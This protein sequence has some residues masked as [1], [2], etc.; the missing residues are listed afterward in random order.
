MPSTQAPGT[1][2][3]KLG[4]FD[5]T[6]QTGYGWNDQ[7]ATLQVTAPS[8]PLTFTESGTASPASVAPGGTVDYGEP[9]G[10]A[11]TIFTLHSELA[12][13]G[14]S[15]GC[16]RASL[17][18][19]IVGREQQIGLRQILHMDEGIGRCKARLNACVMRVHRAVRRERPGHEG[20][21]WTCNSGASGH[22]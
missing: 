20:A 3:V 11:E 2:T 12:T 6:W 15:F 21:P 13:F 16:R 7:A 5:S 10:A 8:S 19:S 4:A 14:E 17:M 18:R 22:W 9:I 1:Y